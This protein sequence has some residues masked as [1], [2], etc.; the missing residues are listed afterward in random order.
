MYGPFTV[1]DLRWLVS[2][3]TLSGEDWVMSENGSQL[4]M[5]SDFVATVPCLPT[6]TSVGFPLKSPVPQQA[7]EPFEGGYY[8]APFSG[9]PWTAMAAALCGIVAVVVSLP[10]F[11]LFGPACVFLVVGFLIAVRSC[12]MQAHAGAVMV[13]LLSLWVVFLFHADRVNWVP[14]LVKPAQ[15]ASAGETTKTPSRPFFFFGSSPQK[16][17]AEA[18]KI[19][20]IP[21]PEPSLVWVEYKASP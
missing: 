3:G 9:L 2:M 13:P 16:K 11:S 4:R 5:L 18:S 8:Y 21:E 12:V 17:P 6:R 10:R 15:M 1:K 7:E 20:E 19:A 14:F